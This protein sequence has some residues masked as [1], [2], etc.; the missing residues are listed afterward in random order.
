MKSM[1]KRGIF[2]FIN[3][4]DEESCEKAVQQMDNF[5]MNGSTLRV[6]HTSVDGFFSKEKKDDIYFSNIVTHGKFRS[7]TEWIVSEKCYF[8]LQ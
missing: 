2:R 4:A 3:Y 8:V 5:V 7:I 6:N 1:S